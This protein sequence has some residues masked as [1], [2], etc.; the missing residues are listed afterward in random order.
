MLCAGHLY[1]VYVLKERPVIATNDSAAMACSLQ[2][3]YV[4]GVLKK[5]LSMPRHSPQV[6]RALIT[7]CWQDD[8]D[9]RPTFMAVFP[10]LQV[11]A[12]R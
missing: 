6:L 8:P 4:V 10:M 3:I 11:S 9:L 1:G 2:V 5:R 7:A 12:P